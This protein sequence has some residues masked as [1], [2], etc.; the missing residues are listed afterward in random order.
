MR[1]WIFWTRPYYRCVN[2]HFGLSFTRGFGEQIS[3][4]VVGKLMDSV[5]RRSK[6]LY[7]SRASYVAV[8]YNCDGCTNLATICRW[9]IRLHT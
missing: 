5:F 6:L 8:G 7:H 4:G 3:C 1:Y 9:R 2:P